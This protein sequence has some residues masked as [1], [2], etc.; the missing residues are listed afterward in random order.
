LLP[1][2]AVNV[3]WRAGYRPYQQPPGQA[4]EV[5]PKTHLVKFTPE[6]GYGLPAVAGHPG[7]ATRFPTP[8]EP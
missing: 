5:R 6:R 4:N 3:G 8:S 1:A 2:R 7:F